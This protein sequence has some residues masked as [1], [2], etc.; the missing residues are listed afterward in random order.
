MAGHIALPQRMHAAT[1][2]PHPNSGRVG[3]VLT[4]GSMKPTAPAVKTAANV[5]NPLLTGGRWEPMG[6]A[7]DERPKLVADL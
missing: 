5:I 1:A 2:I 4:L 7:Y 3:C 6:E